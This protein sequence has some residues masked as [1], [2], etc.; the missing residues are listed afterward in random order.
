MPISWVNAEPLDAFRHLK[1]DLLKFGDD[2]TGCD[3]FVLKKAIE[4]EKAR[5][6]HESKK[7]EAKYLGDDKKI[8][9]GKQYFK[10]KKY[11]E[12]IEILESIQ[13]P[14]FLSNSDRKILELAQKR[15]KDT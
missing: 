7:L 14:E 13:F 11:K 12:C 4:A 5:V 2:F 15:L 3:N 10:L 1:H 6:A 8:T 9:K